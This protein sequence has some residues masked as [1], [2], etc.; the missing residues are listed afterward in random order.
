MKSARAHTAV[1]DVSHG[2][3]FLI[4]HSAAEQNSGHHG[5]HV[6]QMGDWTNKSFLHVAEVNVE[7]FAAGWSPRLRH[8]LRKDISR[9][10]ALNE[11]GA[12]ISNQWR[13]EVL[14]LQRVC[15]S[16]SRSFLAEGP[17]HTTNNL[18]LAVEIYETLFHQPSELQI[19]IEFEMLLGFEPRF[20]RTTQRFA[21]DS[22]ARRM[23]GADA[24]LIA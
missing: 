1:A 7:V 6:A 19:T 8:V 10:N 3:K 23:L 5:N 4:S 11:H 22:F 20:S 12:E 17:K 2:D 16:N 15:G 18:C 13:D 14:R 9:A 21:V 24:H